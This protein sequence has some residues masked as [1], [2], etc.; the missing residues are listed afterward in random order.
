MTVKVQVD[1]TNQKDQKAPA[2][3]QPPAKRIIF[4]NNLIDRFFQEQ[5]KNNNETKYWAMITRPEKQQCTNGQHLF[6]RK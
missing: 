4:M 2:E 6:N 5:S 3:P 1:K